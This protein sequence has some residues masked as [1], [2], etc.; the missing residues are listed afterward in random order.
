MISRRCS[1]HRI[2]SICSAEISNEN[3]SNGNSNGFDGSD[4]T[5]SYDM[6]SEGANGTSNGHVESKDGEEG[7]GGQSNGEGVSNDTEISDWDKSV[8]VVPF[9]VLSLDIPPT[10]LFKVNRAD[11]RSV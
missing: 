6:T 9:T 10:P 7:Q 3:N 2:L 4:Q 8:S 11:L 1:F 5:G